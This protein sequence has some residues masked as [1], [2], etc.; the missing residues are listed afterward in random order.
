MIQ[1][2]RFTAHCETCWSKQ[3]KCNENNMQWKL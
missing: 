1:I 3:C 2:A